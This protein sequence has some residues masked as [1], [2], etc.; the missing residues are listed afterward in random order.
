MSRNL[1]GAS[2]TRGPLVLTGCNGHDNGTT[3]TPDVWAWEAGSTKKVH[4][5]RSR[6]YVPRPYNSLSYAIVM[7]T[8]APVIV[9][10]GLLEIYVTSE[11]V[12]SAAE[13]PQVPT[14]TINTATLSISDTANS[15]VTGTIRNIDISPNRLVYVHLAGN[16]LEVASYNM[17][18]VLNG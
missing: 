16:D 10:S 13:L 18:A 11:P 4:G 2:V 3:Y 1:N 15:R 14:E 7:A 8:T 9:T 6:C 5:I 12:K 17:W